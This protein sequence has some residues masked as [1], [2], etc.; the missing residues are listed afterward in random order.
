M[1]KK[2]VIVKHFG[3]NGH[4]LFSVP[5]GELLSENDMVLVKT[6]RGEQTGKCVCDSFLVEE[7]PLKALMAKYGAKEPLAP[8]IGRFVCTRFEQEDDH[9]NL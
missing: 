9:A 6:K 5:N 3:D 7:S 1:M 8:V 4:Y 2:I